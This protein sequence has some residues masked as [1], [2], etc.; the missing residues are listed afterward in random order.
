MGGFLQRNL[1]NHFTSNATAII[2]PVFM[3]GEQTLLASLGSW[4]SEPGLGHLCFLQIPPSPRAPTFPSSCTEPLSS[5]WSLLGFDLGVGSRLG[6][7]QG[8]APR[9]SFLYVSPQGSG[10]KTCCCEEFSSG[11]FVNV[12]YACMRMVKRLCG[13]EELTAAEFFCPFPFSFGDQEQGQ[14]G[15]SD[16]GSELPAGCCGSKWALSLGPASPAASGWLPQVTFHCLRRQLYP[17]FPS[18]P[19]TT[20]ALRCSCAQ[21]TEVPP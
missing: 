21:F 6:R 18:C 17:T 14:T 3:T 7:W 4:V 9:S 8:L 19:K 10:C 20:H 5:F 16:L 1:E 13:Q 12:E 15:P 11:F 2:I